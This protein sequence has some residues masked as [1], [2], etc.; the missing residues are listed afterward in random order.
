[1][2]SVNLVEGRFNKEEYTEIVSSIYN[3]LKDFDSLDFLR[4]VESDNKEKNINFV[5][6][7]QNVINVVNGSDSINLKL[8]IELD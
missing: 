4:R 7:K 1:M 8:K 3:T 2:T 6:D 5:F